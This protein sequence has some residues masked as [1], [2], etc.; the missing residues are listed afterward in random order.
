MTLQYKET[1]E[2]ELRLLCGYL[3]VGL[4]IQQRVELFSSLHVDQ[5]VLKLLD[6]VLE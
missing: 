5:T 6:K 3:V 1:I 2:H 4:L